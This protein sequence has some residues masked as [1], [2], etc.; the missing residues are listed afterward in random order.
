MKLSAVAFLGLRP[1]PA[2]SPA[3][4]RARSIRRRVSLAWG[5]LFLNCLTFYG[6]GIHIP[7]AAGQA[8]QQGALWAALLVALSVNRD[9][10]IRPNV[11]LC[12]VSV[13][14]IEAL[15]T[16]LHPQYVGTV[17]RFFRLAGF[18][19][20]LWLLTPWWGRRDLLLVRT[21]LVWLWLALGSVILGVLVV[22]G[23][24]LVDGRLS[25]AI[26]DIPATE[27][28][29]YAAVTAGMT[30]VFWFGRMVSGKVTVLVVVAD[31]IMIVLAHTRTAL[32]GMLAGLLVAGLSLIVVKARAR[33]LFVAAGVIVSIGAMTAAG[34]TT[35]WLTRGQ[36]AY[37]LT[38]LTGR[39]NF[40]HMVLVAPRNGFQEIFGFG[41]TNGSINGL[42]V[43]SNWL[44][45]YLEQGLIAV[46][47]CALMVLFLLIVAFFQP[48]GVRRALA[49][50]LIT[51]CFVASITQVGFSQPTTYLLE[52]V[53]AAS[54]MVPPGHSEPDSMRP[55]LAH[56]HRWSMPMP[57]LSE[58]PYGFGSESNN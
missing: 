10:V 42:P 30:V 57:A 20:V 41:L 53:L 55:S 38:T 7:H 5:L 23:H 51:Y 15:V 50:F 56:N 6:S 44:E 21:Y 32:V 47:V 11:F 31:T 26:W 45:A 25:G 52:L 22:P 12:L 54:L 24:A 9:I 48:S 2:L 19:A 8:I 3:E 17:Y 43:D 14:V 58:P 35:S 34:V 36:S 39:T 46:V 1:A 49:L 29:H 16:T 13:L 28:A 4:V 27:V 37:G 33:K 18:V 40:W